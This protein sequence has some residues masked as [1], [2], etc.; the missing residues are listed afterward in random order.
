MGGT[1]TPGVHAQFGS[2]AAD[3]HQPGSAPRPG[4]GSVNR[5][6]RPAL[7]S[8]RR[9]R[10]PRGRCAPG[11]CVAVGRCRGAGC[12]LGRSRYLAATNTRPGLLASTAVEAAWVNRVRQ[13]SRA[14]RIVL[15]DCCYG[16][17]F[18]R[19]VLARAGG[20]V[21]VRDQFREAGLGQGRG[22]VVI[23]ASTAMEYAFEGQQLTNG[24]R[25]AP[26]LFTGALVGSRTPRGPAVD[27]SAP[28]GRPSNLP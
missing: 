12:R 21:D 25:P 16:G 6:E 3:E 7:G 9:G 4:R 18:E 1:K 28:T 17:A 11:T 19:G 2:K 10:P 26:S 27:G 13:R 24:G 15:L 20:D 8:R 5:G 22:R 23:T 14:P